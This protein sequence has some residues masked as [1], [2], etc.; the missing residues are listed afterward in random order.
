VDVVAA[1]HVKPVAVFLV[2]TTAVATP[3]PALSRTVPRIDASTV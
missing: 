3:A 2:V 1:V